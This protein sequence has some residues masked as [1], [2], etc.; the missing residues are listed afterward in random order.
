MT[1]QA[2]VEHGIIERKTVTFLLDK[3]PV[4]SGHAIGVHLPQWPF[5]LRVET[6]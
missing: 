4:Y 2:E 1:G 6:M 5:Y 3:K